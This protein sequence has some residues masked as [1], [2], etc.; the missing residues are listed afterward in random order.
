[1]YHNKTKARTHFPNRSCGTCVACKTKECEWIYGF[2]ELT[3]RPDHVGYILKR[4]QLHPDLYT[5]ID[6]KGVLCRED[7]LEH[8]AEFADTYNGLVILMDGPTGQVFGFVGKEERREEFLAILAQS[9]G[10]QRAQ[11][12]LGEEPACPTSTTEQ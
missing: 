11:A 1:M 12:V 5:A 2:D 10:E 9:V 4:S 3:E 7:V 8:I 6:L